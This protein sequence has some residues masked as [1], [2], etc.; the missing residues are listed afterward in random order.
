MSGQKFYRD[1]D[2]LG[3]AVRVTHKNQ[4]HT[5]LKR[6]STELIGASQY[7]SAAS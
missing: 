2:V 5:F 3:F 4:N 6:E 1:E 7:E